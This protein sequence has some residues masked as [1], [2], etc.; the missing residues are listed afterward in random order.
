MFRSLI[1]DSLCQNNL[2]SNLHQN[3][4]PI[5]LFACAY[6]CMLSK[7]V[8]NLLSFVAFS[9]VSIVTSDR[10]P[11]LNYCR[12]SQ[13]VIIHVYVELICFIFLVTFPVVLFIVLELPHTTVH[14]APFASELQ[15]SSIEAM[16]S[17][18]V[19]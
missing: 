11:Q 10:H 12:M 7:L 19:C 14:Q 1:T 5:H 9:F 3:G 18:E 13:L 8:H 17:M 16:N 2:F 15:K 6:V 4:I